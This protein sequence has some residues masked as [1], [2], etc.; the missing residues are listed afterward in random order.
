M[1]GRASPARRYALI[2]LLGAGVAAGAA[3]AALGWGAPARAGIIAGVCVLLWLGELVPVWVPTLVLWGS[4]PLLMAPFGEAFRPAAVLGWSVD[5]V[6]ALF[7]GGFALAAAAQRQ[8]ADRA[9]AA[10]ALRLSGGR[11]ARMVLLVGAA[12]ALLSMWMSNIAAAALMLAALGPVLEGEDPG[13]PVRQALLLAVALSADVGGIATPIG[14]GPNGIAI[15]AVERQ[16]PVAFVEWMVFGVP[17]AAGLVGA[18]LALILLRLPRGLR[19]ALPAASAAARGGPRVRLLGAVFALTVLLWLTEPLHGVRAW[20]V[21]LGAAALL[22]ATGLLGP[23]DLRRID[24]ATLLLIAGGIGLGALLDAAGVMPLLA[25]ALPLEG[26]SPTA[27]LFALCVL[28]ALMSALMSNTGT[29]TLL[30][31]LVMTVDPRPSSAIVV[32]VACSLGVP[33]VVSTPP[34]AM[35]VGAGLHSRDLLLPGLL[36][37]LGGCLLVAL[38]GGWVLGRVGI[39]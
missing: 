2:A 31:P 15:A 10:L 18:V 28:A 16:H 35:A 5:P 33:F 34:N 32:A 21:A 39:P 29:A 36:L 14:T 13:A 24:W 7:F 22:F 37:M 26:A 8:E 9:V 4:A 19:L 30:V 27:A 3:S 1:T 38:T 23:R 6:L 12:T 25:D 11:A 20:K 17:L